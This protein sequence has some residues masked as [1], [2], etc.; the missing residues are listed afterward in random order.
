MIF[1]CLVGGF[2][3]GFSVSIVSKVNIIFLEYLQF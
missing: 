3:F 2:G 1:V